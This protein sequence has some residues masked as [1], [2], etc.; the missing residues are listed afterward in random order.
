MKCLKSIF[1]MNLSCPINWDLN[2]VTPTK[3]NIQVLLMNFTNRDY[4]V[5]G[6]FLKTK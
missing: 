4:K 1:K 2:L 5:M 3:A 6:V